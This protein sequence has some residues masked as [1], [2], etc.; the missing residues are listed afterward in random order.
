MLMIDFL[1][2]DLCTCERCIATDKYL[3]EALV[4][5]S[6]VLKMLKYDVKINKVEVSS[7]EL[8]ERYRLLSSPTI[9]VNG[10]DICGAIKENECKD[11]AD[12]SGNKVDCRIFTY[13]G[14]EYDQ[15]PAPMIVEG[16]LRALYGVRDHAVKESEYVLPDNLNRFFKS[17]RPKGLRTSDILIMRRRA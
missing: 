15:P 13:N 1:Y 2:L 4:A 10:T 9:R 6:G 3:N 11:C 8:A 16:I 17:E 14:K 5:L 7:R 12:I